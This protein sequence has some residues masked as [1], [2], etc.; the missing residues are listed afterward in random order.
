M[1]DLETEGHD[2]DGRA[3]TD[4]EGKKCPNCHK[5]ECETCKG[6]PKLAECDEC[7]AEPECPECDQLVSALCPDCEH[8]VDCFDEYYPCGNDIH[9]FGGDWDGED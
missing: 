8:C 7:G 4:R 2:L 1:M 3:D 9:D 5:K 6:D